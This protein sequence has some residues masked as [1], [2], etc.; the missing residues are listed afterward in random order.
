MHDV[1][2]TDGV[3]A[4]GATQ[5]NKMYKLVDSFNDVVLSR[6][7]TAGAA[8]NAMEKHLRAVRRHNGQNSYLTYEIISPDGK[9][10]DL[11]EVSL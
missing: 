5:K 1:R 10:V 6:H 4:V 3:V 9:L 8:K 2:H 7:K 11:E